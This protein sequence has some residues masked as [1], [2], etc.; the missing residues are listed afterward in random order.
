ML[1]GIWHVDKA[2]PSGG[3]FHSTIKVASNGSYTCQITSHSPS[4]GL[5]KSGLE[6]TFQVKD[7]VLIDTMT[8]NSNTN[9][10]LPMIS[11]YRILRA[12]DRELVL[13]SKTSYSTNE[14]IF[15]KEKQ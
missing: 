15:R 3:D 4:D 7:G 8:K 11:R 6:G 5:R 10:V 13:E 2:E 12:D 1:P 9:A 14:V